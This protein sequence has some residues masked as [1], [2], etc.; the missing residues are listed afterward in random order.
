MLIHFARLSLLASLLAF[1]LISACGDNGDDGVDADPFDTYQACFDEHHT[2]EAFT[3]PKAITICCLDHPIG[4][5][6]AGVVC[7][8][9]ETTCDTYVTANLVSADVTADT[10][11][12][13]CTDYVTQKGM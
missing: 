12:A 3:A 8:A 7:G 6:D 13:A 10:I 1:P 2:T 4:S 5:N 11:T 9:T